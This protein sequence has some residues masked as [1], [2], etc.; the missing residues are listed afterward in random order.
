LSRGA[1]DGLS[2]VRTVI[3]AMNITP[4]RSPGMRPATN[5]VL[6]ETSIIRPKTMSSTLGGMSEPSVPAAATEPAASEG[7]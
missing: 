3:S 6:I 2:V 7:A 1:S 4:D 5:S